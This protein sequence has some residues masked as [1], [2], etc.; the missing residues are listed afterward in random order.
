MAAPEILF[1][2]TA[3]PF[4]KIYIERDDKKKSG[5]IT[6]GGWKYPSACRGCDCTYKTL[7]VVRDLEIP[8][9]LLFGLF[10]TTISEIV[11]LSVNVIA[12]IDPSTSYITKGDIQDMG[13]QVQMTAFLH[14]TGV[15]QTPYG[16]PRHRSTKDY[17]DCRVMQ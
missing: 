8:L 11:G 14:P 17:R 6:A 4:L 10:L 12:I 13:A 16:E 1:L 2:S 3:A 5:V 7:R 9:W 15:L